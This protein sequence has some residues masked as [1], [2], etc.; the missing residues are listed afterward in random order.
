MKT[1]D[2]ILLDKKMELQLLRVC[3]TLLKELP[4]GRMKH[5]KKGEKKYYYIKQPG[6]TEY[7]AVRKGDRKRALLAI[8]LCKRKWLE[9][10]IG[11]LEKNLSY[12]ERLIK[13]YRTYDFHTIKKLVPEAYRLLEE[14]GWYQMLS[15]AGLSDKVV[16][17]ENPNGRENLIQCTSFGLLVRSKSELIIAE[18]LHAAEIPFRYEPE[19]E[20]RG[21]DGERRLYYPDFVL[22]HPLGGTLYW[23]HLGK[24][25]DY[26]YRKRN[27]LKFLA[28]FANRITP[29]INLIVT[30][31]DVDGAPDVPMLGEIIHW[32]SNATHH[33]A[34]K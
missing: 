31:D 16:Q 20:L 5:T 25:G 3:R 23:E 30:F 21:P 34:I 24:F 2:I 1:K 8:A 33:G 12:E 11:I 6:D 29:G 4:L 17:S 9:T 19:I 18:M 13:N 26:D 28:Y 10:L 14:E 27:E 7:T 22:Q 32:L 15:K